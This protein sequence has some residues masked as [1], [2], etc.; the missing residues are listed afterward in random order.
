LESA[1]GLDE[2]TFVVDSF[3]PELEV[4]DGGVD[5]PAANGMDVLG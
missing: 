5:G 4:F 3:V 2:E 1:G